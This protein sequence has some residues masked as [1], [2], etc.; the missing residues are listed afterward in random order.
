[1]ACK[2]PPGLVQEHPAVET[3]DAGHKGQMVPG[4]DKDTFLAL[5]KQAKVFA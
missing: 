3:A 1:M 4:H 2:R 5:Q